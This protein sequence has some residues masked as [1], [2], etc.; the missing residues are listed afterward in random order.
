MNQYPE[1]PW[2]EE[3]DL[4]VLGTGAAGL[5]AALTA[6]A[7]GSAVLVLEKTEYLG[8][9]T[10][11]SAGTCWVP[12]NSFQRE[13]G[14]FDDHERAVRYLDAVVGNKAPRESR[15]AYLE[16]APKMLDGL[17]ALGVEFRRSP[18]VVDYHSEL[19]ETGKTGRALEPEPFDGRL[20]SRADFRRVRPPVPEFALM[21]GTLMLRRA[22]V[23]ALLKLYTGSL[24]ER[25]KAVALAAKLG[26]RWGWT[27]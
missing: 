21:G 11:Y 5:S 20:L 3:V 18:Q 1:E 7:Q 10:A 19:P 27:D 6:A 15:V 13:D 12:N 25:G 16:A 17:R 14:I 24:A 26:M 9:T 23:A 2:D 8:G 4:L 22:E